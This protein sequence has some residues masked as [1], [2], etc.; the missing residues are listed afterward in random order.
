MTVRCGKKVVARKQLTIYNAPSV[1]AL[2]LKRFQFAGMM[3][4]MPFGGK[5]NKPIEFTQKLDL[6]PFM[7]NKSVRE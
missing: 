2:H 3:G 1:L 4:A 7:S 6:K 5:I